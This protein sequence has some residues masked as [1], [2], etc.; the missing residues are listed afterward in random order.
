MAR[1]TKAQGGISRKGWELLLGRVLLAMVFLVNGWNKVSDPSETVLYMRALD[2]P[3]ASTWL[4]LASGVIEMLGGFALLAGWHARAAARLLAAYLVVVTVF[5]HLL[6]SYRLAADGAREA[7]LFH[8]WLNI[9][10]M[11]GLIILGKAG[12]GGISRD[13]K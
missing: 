3:F 5:A 12:P 4:A 11:G 8:A 2:I 7:E 6:P 10:I 13:G 9:A 1:G